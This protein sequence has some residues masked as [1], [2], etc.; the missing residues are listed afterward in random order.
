MPENIVVD[1]GDVEDGEQGHE[2]DDDGGE[3]ELVAPDVEHPLRPGTVGARLHA[4]EAAAQVYHLPRQE[5]REPRQAGETGC[6]GAE[7]GVTLL[8]IRVVAVDGRDAAA[9][10]N[11]VEAIKDEHE[12]GQAQPCDPEPVH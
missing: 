4:E 5:E 8:A 3:E 2:A 12:G 11:V 1:D 10:F 7:D 6:A 9:C